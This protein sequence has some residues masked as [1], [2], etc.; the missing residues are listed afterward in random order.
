MKTHHRHPPLGMTEEDLEEERAADRTFRLTVLAI[1]SF[2]AAIV[3]IAV[4]AT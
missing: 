4:L 2:T 1:A 3:L